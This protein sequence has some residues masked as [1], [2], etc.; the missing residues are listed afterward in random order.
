MGLN[1]VLFQL[2]DLV[3]HKKDLIVGDFYKRDKQEK[4]ENN[5]LRIF[6]KELSVFLADYYM[7]I[8]IETTL[9]IPDSDDDYDAYEAFYEKEIY[10]RYKEIIKDILANDDMA[11]NYYNFL[12]G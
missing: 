7:Q 8:D 2:C 10:P 4:I 9:V 6:D 1:Q 3:K 5:Q 12:W 11:D